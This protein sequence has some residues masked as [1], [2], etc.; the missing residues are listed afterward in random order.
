MGTPSRLI[1]AVTNDTCK[2]Y[3]DPFSRPARQLAVANKGSLGVHPSNVAHSMGNFAQ[4]APN[5]RKRIVSNQNG[6]AGQWDQVTSDSVRSAVTFYPFID[7]LE[8]SCIYSSA[9]SYLA[10]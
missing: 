9:R 7:H 2:Q 4:I 5:V 8:T 3:P 10:F 6:Q 1:R